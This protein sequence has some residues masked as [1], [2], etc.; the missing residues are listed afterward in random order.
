MWQPFAVISLFGLTLALL[1][2]P[3]LPAIIELRR[4]TDATPL[5]VVQDYEVDIHHFAN[6]FR[7]YI[8]SN[9]QTLLHTCHQTG[10]PH[11]DTLQDGISYIVLPDDAKPVFSKK[12]LH[13]KITQRLFACT[14]T[15]YLP[16]DMSYLSE[17]Y[18]GNTLHG[19]DNDIY[20]AVLSEK[21]V[22]F[23][24]NSILLRWL[25]A[26]NIVTVN[27]G[28]TLHGRVSAGQLIHFKHN[29]KFERL[30][31]PAIEFGIPQN[32]THQVTETIPFK[33]ED[34]KGKIYVSGRR[35]LINGNF[36]IPDN[37]QVDADLVV[38]GKLNIG[39]NVVI[40]GSI[41]SHKDLH[42]GRNVL[43]DGSTISI[44]NIYFDDCCQANGPVL[45]EKDIYLS[46]SCY[47]GTKNQAVTINARHIQIHA[48]SV[49]YG[50][51][52]ARHGGEARIDTE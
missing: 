10:E 51:L 35:W 30:H 45:S 36:N 31:A 28:C 42:I 48:G 14:G 11:S 33:L 40:K 21:D 9:L 12:E 3:L 2:L 19:G 7:S 25:H 38:R 8:H 52:W 16:G 20:R 49:I 22:E 41:K 6:H 18:T 50:T 43:I 24:E 34:Y 27:N 37:Y 26:E 17:I 5:K 39:N 32:N 15:L 1:I 23:G 44:N 46:K 29:S 13:K 4:K 47:I